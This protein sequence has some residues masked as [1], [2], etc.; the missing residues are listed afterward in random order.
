MQR[1]TI[2]NAFSKQVLLQKCIY[3]AGLTLRTFFY[4]NKVLSNLAIIKMLFIAQKSTVAFGFGRDCSLT[5]VCS[6]QY[7]CCS[8][9]LNS[10]EMNL[11][12]LRLDKNKTC[13]KKTV[14]SKAPDLLRPKACESSYKKKRIKKIKG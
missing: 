12:A 13:S 11:N 7:Q 1:E 3:M 6:P 5:L 2:E 9:M 8:S 14:T 4:T 10:L